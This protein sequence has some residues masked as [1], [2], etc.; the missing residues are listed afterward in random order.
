MLS[1]T[2]E[3]DIEQEAVQN[4]MELGCRHLA[5]NMRA[6]QPGGQFFVFTGTHLLGAGRQASQWFGSYVSE[7]NFTQTIDDKSI[8]LLF[9][10]K[11]LPEVLIAN[12]DLNGEFYATLEDENL[13]EPQQEKLELEFARELQVSKRDDRKTYK[14]KCEAVFSLVRDYSEQQRKWAL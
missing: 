2:T 11:R 9:Y 10:E 8:V 14:S 12:C 3:D 6:G 4:L 7:F 1:I 5:E 13:D